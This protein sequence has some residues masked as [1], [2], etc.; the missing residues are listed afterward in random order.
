MSGLMVVPGVPRLH[1]RPVSAL[2]MAGGVCIQPPTI[3]GCTPRIPR[4]AS[5]GLWHLA[6]ADMACGYSALR[7]ELGQSAT[8]RQRGVLQLTHALPQTSPR[9]DTGVRKEHDLLLRPPSRQPRVVGDAF[10]ADKAPIIS[11]AGGGLFFFWQLGVLKYLQSHFD[12]SRVHF[13]GA[14]AGGLIATLTCCGVD[15]DVAVDKAHKLSVENGVFERPLGV[16]GIWGRL[17][18]DWLEDL[19]PEEAHKICSGRLKLVVTDVFGWTTTYAEEFESR[20]D[21]VDACMASAHVPFVLDWK[22]FAGYRGKPY[23]DGSLVDFFTWSNSEHLTAG[24]AFVLDYTQDEML[25]FSRFDFLKL[26]DIHEVR[27]LIN[28]GYQYGERIVTEGEAI[29]VLESVRHGL[30]RTPDVGLAP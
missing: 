1:Q 4:G 11:G 8:S 23:L 7:F 21:L 3:V 25:T 15:L 19:L 28:Q 20:N 22:P 26:R 27:E 29:E 16:V 24:G 18:R 9:E 13:R 12:L 14:S 30:P 5:Q 17:I 6:S 10:Q 2:P